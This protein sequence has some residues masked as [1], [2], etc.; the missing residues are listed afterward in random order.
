MLEIFTLGT[1]VN[2]QPNFL[3]ENHHKDYS[4]NKFYLLQL[5]VYNCI[6]HFVKSC[7]FC[8]VY[9]GTQNRSEDSLPGMVFDLIQR[10]NTALLTDAALKYLYILRKHASVHKK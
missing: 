4:L 9:T 3:V 10:A 1:F 6:V 5:S 7:R 8:I 2:T